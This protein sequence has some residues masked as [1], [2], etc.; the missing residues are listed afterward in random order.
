MKRT[1][2]LLSAVAFV[3]AMVATGC[4]K[5]PL[6]DMS[7]EESRI[8]ITN[9]DSTANF[10]SYTT[11]SIVDSV[12]VLSNR[13]DSAKKE[14]T[15]YDQKLIASVSAAMQQRGYTLVNKAAKPD[16]AI[17]LTRIDNTFSAISWNPGWWGGY[18]DPGYW[19]FPGGG[20]YWPSYYT[21]YRVNERQVAIDLF[22][23]KNAQNKQ[24]KSV[25][26]ALWRG[27]GVW[28]SNN[29]DNMV[30]TSFDQSPYL[31]K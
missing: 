16:L 2:F 17:N 4:R 25:W 6:N 20:W 30:K 8:Y 1:L 28:N 7:D 15:D 13:N 19:G 24:L 31:K 12:V 21:V 22:D 23:L 14:L 3:V 10:S 29:I 5:D 26:N 18:W 11:F 9:H 27:T